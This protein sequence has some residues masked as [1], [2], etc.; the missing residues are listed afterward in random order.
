MEQPMT[1]LSP[2]LKRAK[3]TFMDLPSKADIESLM[4]NSCVGEVA[5]TLGFVF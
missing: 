1:A 4:Q 2:S 3:L 5:M